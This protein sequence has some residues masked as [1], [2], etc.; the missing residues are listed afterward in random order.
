[1]PHTC[2][3]ELDLHR[4]F[5]GQSGVSEQLVGFFQRAVFCWDPIDGQ[6]SVTNLQQSTPGHKT[7]GLVDL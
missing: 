2:N 3:I 7:Q 6:Q 1:M 4:D 5:I